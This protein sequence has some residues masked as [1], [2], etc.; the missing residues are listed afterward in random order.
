MDNTFEWLAV[1]AARADEVGAV[2][3]IGS[4]EIVVLV[5]SW[6]P[7]VG[8]VGLLVWAF[9]PRV[10]AVVVAFGFVIWWAAHD[11]GRAARRAAAKLVELGG[12]AIAC[13]AGGGVAFG[14]VGVLFGFAAG[15]ALGLGGLYEIQR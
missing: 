15:I 1:G 5:F 3:R 7:I 4:L 13:A 12:V 2:R 10:L 8:A 14:G 9:G 6:L 11:V